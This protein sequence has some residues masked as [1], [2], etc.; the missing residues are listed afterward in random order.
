MFDP[1]TMRAAR[2]AMLQA[3][4]TAF[5]A[6]VEDDGDNTLRIEL[7]REDNGRVEI[8]VTHGHSGMDTSGYSL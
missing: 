4:L 5:F 6:D 8:D 3:A 2:A 7:R 1:T